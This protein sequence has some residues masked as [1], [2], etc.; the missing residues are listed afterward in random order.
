MLGAGCGE[1]PAQGKI[2]SMSDML[3]SWFQRRLRPR[4]AASEP[5]DLYEFSSP[6]PQNAVNLLTG[7]THA[8]PPEFGAVAGPGAMY[9]DPRIH[10]AVEK[11]GSL[12]GKRLAE[13]GPLEGSHTYM[14]ERAGAHRID[15]IEANKGA[16]LR[17]LVAKEV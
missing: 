9:D 13:L 8:F 6:S 1:A 4:P 17:C 15:A 3:S 10:W 12:E 5:G 14:L 16:F 7:W 11:F 2:S